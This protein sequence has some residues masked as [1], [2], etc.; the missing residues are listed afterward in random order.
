MEEWIL[1]KVRLPEPYQHILLCS[2]KTG[3]ICGMFQNDY[4]IPDDNY[5]GCPMSSNY[6]ISINAYW[7]PLPG[8]EWLYDKNT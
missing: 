4:L 1:F 2:K 3:Y 7:K 5:D 6:L 8:I